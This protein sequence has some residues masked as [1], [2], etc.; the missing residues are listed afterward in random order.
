M[1]DYEYLKYW[2]QNM[3]EII[4]LEKL[5]KDNLIGYFETKDIEYLEYLQNNI[6]ELQKLRG[7]I[8]NTIVKHLT[9]YHIITPQD[10]NIDKTNINKLK[11][12]IFREVKKYPR[13]NKNRSIRVIIDL[14]KLPNLSAPPTI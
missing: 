12:K 11:I 2:R 3:E 4:L 14:F 6:E 9:N 8:K 1:I 5:M 13:T 7:K 10:M